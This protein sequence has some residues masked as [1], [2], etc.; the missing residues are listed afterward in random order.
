MT[1]ASGGGGLTL[2]PHVVCPMKWDKAGQK[3]AQAAQA[4]L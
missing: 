1:T 4:Q 2:D 3:R